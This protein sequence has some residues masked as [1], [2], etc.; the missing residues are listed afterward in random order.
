M[1]ELSSRNPVIVRGEKIGLGEAGW[2]WVTST[3]GTSSEDNIK[4]LKTKEIQPLSPPIKLAVFMHPMGL[5]TV[6]DFSH[7]GK[8]P[9]FGH[10]SVIFLDVLC[11]NGWL[12]ISASS[13]CSPEMITTNL[14][15][16]WVLPQAETN[17]NDFVS[18]ENNNHYSWFYFFPEY[19]DYTKR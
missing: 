5:R 10:S 2:I 9:Q 4:H 14:T 12:L 8:G 1:K 3:C 6:P 11:E 15:D 16:L 18:Q 13:S 17:E 19:L 7:K